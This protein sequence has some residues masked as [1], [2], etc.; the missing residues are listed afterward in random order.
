M[1]VD[2]FA[3]PEARSSAISISTRRDCRPSAEGR[4]IQTTRSTGCVLLA[5]AGHGGECAAWNAPLSSE[6]GRLTKA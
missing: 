5:L 6:H 2:V 4:A 3:V 1:A